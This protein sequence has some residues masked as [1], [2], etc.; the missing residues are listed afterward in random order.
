M[1]LR[2]NPKWSNRKGRLKFVKQIL[3]PF[4]SSFKKSKQNDEEK[5]KAHKTF[6]KARS[7]LLNIAATQTRWEVKQTLFN[8]EMLKKELVGLEGAEEVLDWLE[9]GAPLDLPHEEVENSVRQN[10]K[11]HSCFKNPEAILNW[12]EQMIKELQKGH[13]LGPFDR[14]SQVWNGLKF[15]KHRSG[16]AQ[17]KGIPWKRMIRDFRV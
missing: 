7:N 15:I 10:H 11:P 4:R 6:N 13:L 8:I 17:M 16:M 9:H 1:E 2:R 14:D 5:A 3:K 12:S